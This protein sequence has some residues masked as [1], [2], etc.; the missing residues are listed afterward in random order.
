MVRVSSFRIKRLYDFRPYITEG[1]GYQVG[2]THNA[3]PELIMGSSSIPLIFVSFEYRLGQFGFLGG[4]RA[5]FHH[6]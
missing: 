5:L 2:N 4:P 3:P 6:M 1:G